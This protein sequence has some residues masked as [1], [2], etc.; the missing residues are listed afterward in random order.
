MLAAQLSSAIITAAQIP[1]FCQNLIIR[2]AANIAN[3]VVVSQ[4]PCPTTELRII[5]RVPP[6]TA[7]LDLPF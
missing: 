6:T 7:M 2:V 5:A 3:I 1:N 4:V